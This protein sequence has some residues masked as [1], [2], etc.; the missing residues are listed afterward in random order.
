MLRTIQRN[1]AHSMFNMAPHRLD[2]EIISIYIHELQL[3]IR[4]Q[5]KMIKVRIVEKDY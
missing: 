1:Y 4:C 3:L 2:G 5:L